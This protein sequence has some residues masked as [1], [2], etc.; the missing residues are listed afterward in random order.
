MLMSALRYHVQ[1]SLVRDQHTELV[2]GPPICSTVT[3][4]HLFYAW[5][6]AELLEDAVM[7]PSWV[8]LSR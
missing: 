6:D 7:S 8:L 4:G 5:H 3:W 1:E 2:H